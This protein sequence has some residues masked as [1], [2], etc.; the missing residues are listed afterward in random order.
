M[1]NKK[2]RCARRYLYRQEARFRYCIEARSFR[3]LILMISKNQKSLV[4]LQL[5]CREIEADQRGYIDNERL[6]FYGLTC[7]MYSF[8]LISCVLNHKAFVVCQKYVCTK[9]LPLFDS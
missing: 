9:R 7:P 6:L 3:S 1:P 5:L 2:S 8:A 4:S